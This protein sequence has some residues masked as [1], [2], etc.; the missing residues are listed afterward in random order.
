MRTGKTPCAP[1]LKIGCAWQIRVHIKINKAASKPPIGMNADGTPRRPE[2]VDGAFSRGDGAWRARS[3]GSKPCS[4][5]EY[6]FFQAV[7]VFPGSRG[8]GTGN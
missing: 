6:L 8:S 5:L 4:M 7:V 3:P 2:K 1:C